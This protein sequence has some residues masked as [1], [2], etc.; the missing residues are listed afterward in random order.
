MKE[1]EIFIGNFKDV[2][3]SCSTMF[4]ECMR[5][6]GF[7]KIYIETLNVDIYIKDENIKKYAELETILKTK[8]ID[9]LNDYAF[10]LYYLNSTN[11]DIRTDIELALKLELKKGIEVGKRIKQNEIKKALDL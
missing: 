4:G 9:E 1:R 6:N 3:L 2:N 10:E 11:S 5:G 8:D 7:I